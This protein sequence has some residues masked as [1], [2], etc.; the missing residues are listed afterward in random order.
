MFTLHEILYWV[1]LGYR[2]IVPLLKELT[3][4][5]GRGKTY[6]SNSIHIQSNQDLKMCTVSGID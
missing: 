3:V 1:M 4:A 2:G 6:A 5:G